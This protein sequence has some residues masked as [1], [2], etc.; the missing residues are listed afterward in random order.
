MDQARH[1]QDR[2]KKL[3]ARLERTDSDCSDL[4]RDLALYR[5]AVETSR[6]GIV[7]YDADARL[8]FCN[9]RYKELFHKSA[10]ILVPGTHIDESARAI[11]ESGQIVEAQGN[12]KGWAS[13]RLK[14]HR[15]AVE[16][17]FFMSLSDG[18]WLRG[19]NYRTDDGGMLGIRTDITELKQ[20]EEALRAETADTRKR[21]EA[22][23]DNSPVAMYI[24]DKNYR[25]QAVNEAFESFYGVTADELIGKTTAEAMPWVPSPARTSLEYLVVAEGRAKS[26]GHDVRTPDGKVST[27]ITTKFPIFDSDGKLAGIGCVGVDVTP[28][29]QAQRE[30]AE[31][32]QLLEMTLRSIEQGYA[33]IDADMRVITCNQK[34]LDQHHYADP[35]PQGG[36]PLRDILI[37][38]SK[39]GIYGTEDPV[40][41]L[42]ERIARLARPDRPEWEER[43]QPDGRII[44]VRRNALSGGGYVVTYTDITE[45]KGAERRAENARRLLHEALDALPASV[46]L[47][48]RDERL[49]F[50]NRTKHHLF[51]WQ[52]GLHSPG[53]LFETQL[54]DSVAR[55]MAPEAEGRSEAWIQDRLREYREAAQNVETRHPGNHW[56]LS[57]YRKTSDGG[58]VAIRLDISSRKSTEKALRESEENFRGLVENSILGIS[59][60]RYSQILFVNQSLVDMFGYDSA[61]ELMRV[62][63]LIQIAAVHERK[64]LAGYSRNRLSGKPAPAQYEYEGVKKDGGRIWVQRSSHVVNWR[65][66]RAVQSTFVD[67]TKRR[68]AEE[69][70]RNALKAAETANRAKS[71]FLA[72]MSHELR[73][74]LNAIIGFSEIL[75]REAFGPLGHAKYEGYIGDITTSARHLL[76]MINDILDMSKIEA[77][78]YDVHPEEIDL[79]AVVGESVQM[80]HGQ[81]EERQ[82]NLTMDI[83]EDLPPLLADPRAVRQI[84][85]NLLS[86]AIKFTDPHG[87]IVVSS[88]RTPDDD[89]DLIVSDTGI[90]IAPQH[91]KQILLPFG[92]VGS[93]QTAGQPG[94]GLG[95]PI[96]RSLIEMH[97]GRL[98]VVSEP[99]VGTAVTV[100]FPGRAALSKSRTAT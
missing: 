43:L 12:A 41:R 35:L 38:Y 99:G 66:I 72:K 60:T 47:Y 37:E 68:E 88:R 76:D 55:G 74:P 29:K 26:R 4:H 19:R 64:R 17:P 20:H 89:I 30:L 1:L 98:R 86:N 36:L 3:E 49:V 62:G 14:M 33:F 5:K 52:S 22:F 48:N 73:T 28:F 77:G 42:D 53:V 16:E 6:D 7:L 39:T 45:L 80:V 2:V 40:K 56:L 34:F 78:R 18:T 94:T 75:G 21:L 57:S 61:E 54:R 8:V 50:C 23:F 87:G 24:K 100:S 83:E 32:S 13:N 82:L 11:A 25:F 70:L 31:K 97:E 10:H 63:Q 84:L 27:A 58:T 69:S 95:L 44:D 46:A 96:V 67:I 15:D 90:G 51:H 59:I 91:L 85:L 79:R 65:G 81:I 9:Q 93:A 92:Q 71:E